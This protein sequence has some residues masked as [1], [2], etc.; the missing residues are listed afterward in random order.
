[1]VV[2][3]EDDSSDTDTCEPP[4]PKDT[5]VE[6]VDSL[7]KTL[8]DNV[9]NHR[10]A[11]IIRRSYSRKTEALLE[12]QKGKWQEFCLALKVDPHQQLHK[13]D[14]SVFKAFL[15]WRVEKGR[16][17]KVSAIQNYWKALSSIYAATTQNWLGESILADVGGFIHEV[18]KPRY[19]LS[20][21]QKAKAGLYVE[22]LD[23]LLSHHWLSDTEVFPHERLRLQLAILL[24]IAG[25]TSSRPTALLSLRYRD[26]EF[27]VFPPTK[28]LGRSQLTLTVRLTNTKRRGYKQHAVK[29][30]FHE[31]ENLIH[32]PV[33]GFLALALADGA[34]HTPTRLE[35]IYSL[36]VPDHQDRVTLYFKPE[37]ADRYV[38]QRMDGVEGPL[39]YSQA[40][41]ALQR[42]GN[43]CGYLDKLMF[44]D[45]RRASGKMLNEAYTPEERNQIMGHTGGTSA[46]YRN[47][48]M[49]EFVDKDVQSVYFGVTPRDNVI[50][51]IGRIRRNALAPTRL[52]QDQQDEV[53][54]DAKLNEAY[55]SRDEAKRLVKLRCGTV[56]SARQRQGELDD[57]LRLLLQKYESAAKKALNLRTSLKGQ[58]LR[59]SM[60]DFHT[61]ADIDLVT[62]SAQSTQQEASSSQPQ[63]ELQ[64]RAGIA[65]ALRDSMQQY[66][67]RE[68]D[69]IRIRLVENMANL[70]HMRETST[71]HRGTKRAVHCPE[72]DSDSEQ[73]VKRRKVSSGASSSLQSV[74]RVKAKPV[75]LSCPFCQLD[76]SL[77]PVRKNH[78]Y[79]RIDSLGTHIFKQHFNEAGLYRG[80]EGG[81]GPEFCCPY[82]D[83]MELLLGAADFAGH[84]HVVHGLASFQKSTLPQAATAGSVIQALNQDFHLYTA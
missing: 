74:F 57:D 68:L 60:R 15:E 30:G 46:V 19:N 33:L 66:E 36:Q 6:A 64:E 81:G 75:N 45:L 5:E 79:A 49:P 7:F 3:S 41:Y 56:A 38:F 27:A 63:Y 55:A 83:C 17:L 10:K 31:Q 47:Y 69:R 72:S 71:R 37:I 52:T 82:S 77:G 61:L 51:A 20:E 35:K 78:Q 39:E 59:Q 22:D 9:E 62:G 40:R 16:I 80:S 2:R 8:W 53:K 48:Y 42:L 84:A 58:T 50:R 25:A 43:S 21:E 54:R 76:P 4:S 73:D 34:F 12:R 14:A 11:G 23:I 67:G 32:C 18:L 44:Y 1:M 24:T 29:F 13:A 26:L 65:E 28:G 70:C